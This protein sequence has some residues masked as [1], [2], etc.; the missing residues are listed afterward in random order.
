MDWTEFEAFM[1]QNGARFALRWLAD[2]GALQP[3]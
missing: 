3:S 2:A 1:D